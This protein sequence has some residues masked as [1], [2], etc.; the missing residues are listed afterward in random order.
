MRRPA[1]YI[2]SHL[3]GAEAHD[4]IVQELTILQCAQQLLRE[5][6]LYDVKYL[7][8]EFDRLIDERMERHGE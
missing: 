7:I 8:D 2:P 5:L 6:E 3:K 4:R 1:P